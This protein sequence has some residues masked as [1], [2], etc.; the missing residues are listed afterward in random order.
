MVIGVLQFELLIPQA[1]CLK[2]KRR[3]VRSVKDRLHREH[4]VAVAEVGAHDM[5]NVAMLG[6]AAVSAEGQ[7]VADTLD[8]INAKLRGLRGAEL[9][10][11]SRRLFD[12]EAMAPSPTLADTDGLARELLGRMGEPIEEADE[13]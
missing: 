6:V 2:D 13:R 5:L 7:R 1:G 11:T 9:G 12:A 3:V 10:A 8:A 4:L